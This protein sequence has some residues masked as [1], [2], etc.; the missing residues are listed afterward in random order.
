MTT[1]KERRACEMLD[2]IA[3]RQGRQRRPLLSENYNLGDNGPSSDYTAKVDR[4]VEA[5]T[6]YA[7]A[8]EWVAQNDPDKLELHNLWQ[9]ALSSGRYDLLPRWL[10]T[11]F[12]EVRRTMRENA[13]AA[14]SPEPQDEFSH[15][16]SARASALQDAGG[17]DEY[18]ALIQ[19]TDEIYSER[20]EL[21]E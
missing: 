2:R 14:D 6:G 11:K 9:D 10:H 20:P 16:V 1:E 4:A 18:E 12:H 15:L 19:A 21:Y 8:A 5:G 7:E 3:Q 17:L 13:K